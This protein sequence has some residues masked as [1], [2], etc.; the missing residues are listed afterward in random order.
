M[1]T[2]KVLTTLALAALAFVGCQKDLVEITP[3]VPVLDLEATLFHATSENANT[4]TAI[5]ADGT[6]IVWNSGDAISVFVD[7]G[8]EG[9]H[10]FVSNNTEPAAKAYFA[11]SLPALGDDPHTFWAVYPYAENVSV[12]KGAVSL[13]IPGAQIAVAGSFDPAAFPAVAVSESRVFAFRNVCSLLKIKVGTDGIYA[14][15]FKGNSDEVINGP[16]TVTLSDEGVPTV[17]MTGVSDNEHNYQL[18]GIFSEE[19]LSQ[20]EDY[21]LALP[22]TEFAKGGVFTLYDKDGNVLYE[23]PA[24]KALTAVRS[25]VHAVRELPTITVER[26]WGKFPTE[27]PTFTTN[28]DRCATTDGEYVYVA[29]TSQNSLGV[30]AISIADPTVVKEVCMDGV[31][32]E[33]TFPTSCVRTIYDP[34]TEKYILLLSNMSMTGG[35]HLYL[36]AYTNGI[37]A[38]PV[39]L[40]SSYTLP[41]WAERRFGDFFTVVGDWQNGC[42]WFRTNNPGQDGASTTARWNIS[43]GALTNQTPDGFNYGYA[44]SRGK[45]EFCQYDMSAKLGLLTTDS[46]GL[47]YDLNSGE[48]QSWN[49]VT[50]ESMRRMFGITPFAFN[51]KKFIAFT[52]MKNDNAARS[53]LTIINDKGSA[54]E[55]K[56]SLEEND[57]FYQA[58]LQ[59][60]ELGASTNVMAGATYS[61]QTSASC[62]VAVADDCVYILGHHHNVGLSVFKMSL[63]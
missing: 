1:K 7:E 55:F 3:E 37:D 48:G 60:D 61:D 2:N 24:D 36:Y 20:D 32:R 29:K 21:Y 4:R 30:W 35:E 59:I 14:V 50:Q 17:V 43:N 6:T 44:A 54:A 5:D 42:V 40:L 31:E 28:L 39:K 15:T 13:E 16:A 57:I 38:A 41:T 63:K 18:S 11:G 19:P 26:V 12:Q 52:K 49:S 47:F 58:A 23:I 33:G 8:T 62:A 45:G 25:K 51:G 34:T 22:P 10:K 53:W 56:A 9:G 27:W 46:V